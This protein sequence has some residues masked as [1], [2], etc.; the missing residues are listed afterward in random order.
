MPSLQS[1]TDLTNWSSVTLG[2]P[3]SV[4]FTLPTDAS[5]GVVSDVVEFDSNETTE[6][7]LNSSLVTNFNANSSL[8]THYVASLSSADSDFL[9]TSVNNFTAGTT[10]IF[11]PTNQS[12]M[13]TLTTVDVTAGD[14]N[15]VPSTLIFNEVGNGT[16]AMIIF[17]NSYTG[18]T[19]M[20]QIAT[21]LNG[22]AFPYTS[23]GSTLTRTLTSESNVDRGDLSIVATN[24]TNG[25][26]NT[27]T[28]LVLSKTQDGITANTT[29]VSGAVA[30][31][32]T[33]VKSGGER[34]GTFS[35]TLNQGETFVDRQDDIV[36]GC[37]GIY[38]RVK[39][40]NAATLQVNSIEQ[41]I[42][43][44]TASVTSGAT[45]TGTAAVTTT[46]VRAGTDEVLDLTG[47]DAWS[48]P[49]NTGIQVS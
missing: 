25:N 35:L 27:G 7:A 48:N 22:T 41:E 33:I 32:F 13:I 40:I 10:A 9:L 28:N 42:V 3:S 15:D 44:I 17:A 20:G 36:A 47:S 23:T 6:L 46:V 24:G 8:S 39:V 16:L 38:L 29:P 26:I 43:T 30:S 37:R 49:I 14:P 34:G 21:A 2:S 4:S 5:T 12:G 1:S 45:P 11:T 31:V 19:L 18:T